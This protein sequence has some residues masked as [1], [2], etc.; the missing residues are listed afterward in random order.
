MCNGLQWCAMV[1]N[2]LQW[3]AMVCNGLQWR[4][5]AWT[6]P[7]GEMYPI[8]RKMSWVHARSAIAGWIGLNQV[9][10]GWVWPGI[11]SIH[12][13]H[14]TH[15][16]GGDP[17]LGPNFRGW[18]DGRAMPLGWAWVTSRVNAG[19]QAVGAKIWETGKYV[20]LG[21]MRRRRRR[22]REN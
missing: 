12:A 6:I 15:A 16:S 20:E 17:P 10:H 22:Q 11:L 4:A 1:C 13:T 3:C 18:A 8:H 5:M 7:P 9:G 14:A 2:G 21:G 19:Q